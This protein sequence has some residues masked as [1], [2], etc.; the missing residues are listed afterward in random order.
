MI[1]ADDKN[2]TKTSGLKLRLT[3][4]REGLKPTEIA[5]KGSLFNIHLKPKQRIN[6]EQ[7]ILF[8]RFVRS[9]HHGVCDR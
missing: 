8:N 7:K 2:A 4:Q 6:Y 5:L 3:R 9:A 1:L